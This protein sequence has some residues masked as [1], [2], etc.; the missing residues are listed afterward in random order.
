[1]VAVGVAPFERFV[2]HTADLDVDKAELKLQ[3][4]FER[5]RPSEVGAR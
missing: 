1:M 5:M 3:S 2:P 4:R